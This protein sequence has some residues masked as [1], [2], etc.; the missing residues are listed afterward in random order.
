MTSF[1]FVEEDFEM[2]G[3]LLLENC[4]EQLLKNDLVEAIKSIYVANQQNWTNVRIKFK[5]YPYA[6]PQQFFEFIYQFL[7][8]YLNMDMTKNLKIWSDLGKAIYQQHEEIDESHMIL[9]PTFSF[10]KFNIS[11]KLLSSVTDLEIKSYPDDPVTV[12]FEEGVQTLHNVILTPM[13]KSSH[14][15]SATLNLPS[16]L[17][18]HLDLFQLFHISYTSSPSSYSCVFN[19]KAVRN[20]QGLKE[21]PFEVSKEQ[22]DRIK[23]YKIPLTF[24]LL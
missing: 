16:S 4:K 18:G 5:N 14:N 3:D 13:W 17:K 20:E 21:T 2:F 9:Y 15:I 8:L 11:Q 12:T 24:N 10:N 22:L 7:N 1:E 19:I 23:E 6:S